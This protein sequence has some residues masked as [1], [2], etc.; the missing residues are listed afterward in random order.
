MKILNK[1]RNRVIILSILTAFCL[2]AVIV[3]IAGKSIEG[4]IWTTACFFYCLYNLTTHPRGD[5][6]K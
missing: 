5:F 6:E 3:N 4:T 2:V 1:Y